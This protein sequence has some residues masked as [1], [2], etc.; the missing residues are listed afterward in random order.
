MTVAKNVWRVGQG[1]QSLVEVEM[2]LLFFSSKSTTEVFSVQGVWHSPND[3]HDSCK[4]KSHELWRWNLFSLKLYTYFKLII[5]SSI[6]SVVF[7]LIINEVRIWI[8]EFK[9]WNVYCFKPLYACVG[10]KTE[11][12]ITELQLLPLIQWLIEWL[13]FNVKW[14][15]VQL[16]HDENKLIFN[17]MM[18]RSALF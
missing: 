12:W 18:M 7:L 5:M 9:H 17:E 1:R 3:P 10:S 16:Y 8:F 11:S 15:I 13:L 14:A 6:L 2:L 4:N